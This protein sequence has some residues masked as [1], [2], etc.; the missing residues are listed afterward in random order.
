MP[1]RARVRLSS[2]WLIVAALAIAT[3]NFVHAL[4]RDVELHPAAL[5]YDFRAF[6]CAGSVTNSGAD[7]YLAG[8]LRTCE[9]SVSAQYASASNVVIPAPVPGYALALYARWLAL[10]FGFAATLWTLALLAASVFTV[11]GLRALTGLPLGVVVAAVALS[12]RG[13]RS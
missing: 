11:V 1:E 10:P 4:P 12:E 9:R 3:V 7:P 8:P 6:Y 2:R 13:F 5:G